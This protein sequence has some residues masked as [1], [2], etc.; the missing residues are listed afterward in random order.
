MAITGK[1]I[2]ELDEA[3][4]NAFK[5]IL[6]IGEKIIDVTY[7]DLVSAISAQELIPGQFY[8]ITDFQTVHWM[9]TL[10]ES[11]EI[12]DLIYI[13]DG[14]GAKVVNT[15]D[16]VE[17]LVVLATSENT[18][19]KEAYS[20]LYP[21]DIIYYE[22][23]ITKCVSPFM[24]EFYDV[25]LSEAVPGF[26]GAILKRN[27]TIRNIELNMDWRNVKYRMW[28]ITQPA[29]NYETEYSLN[30]LV[31]GIDS[32]IYICIKE[33][34]HVEP[35]VSE[36]W[37][38]YWMELVDLTNNHSGYI[39]HSPLGLY[40]S[41]L[42][43]MS[44]GATPY[45]PVQDVED[46]VDKKTIS[47][48]DT[49]SFGI[50]SKGGMMFE[51]VCF[52]FA[53]FVIVGQFLF[54]T[55][56]MQCNAISSFNISYLLTFGSGCNGL[57]FEVGNSSMIFGSGC[58]SM[59]FGSDCRVMTFGSGC[60]NMTFGSGCRVMTFGSDCR[61]MTFG[62]Y[63]NSMTF[64]S[65]C[66]SMSFE[67]GCYQMTFPNN[68][69]RNGFKQGVGGIDYTNGGIVQI[70]T[71]ITVTHQ[72]ANNGSAEVVQYYLDY[73]IDHY[74]MVYTTGVIGVYVL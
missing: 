13:E 9:T 47:D 34:F 42:N 25:T 44:E 37:G 53:C 65:N 69:A 64:G 40:N 50:V 3:S 20:A 49:M 23:D 48:L 4:V 70:T 11:H 61:I 17:P 1:K 5:D 60:G 52:D 36:G 74:E 62:S 43:R 67:S 31:T 18:I 22:W 39:A 71:G 28:N 45:I 15:A 21:Q 56:G 55:F 54:T 7:A 59:T 14:E 24:K 26:K 33:N 72:L 51:H 57:I 16:A 73:V 19:S 32:K 12:Q 35:S 27:D 66:H 10:G 29:Y 8:R 41:I 2:S 6:G 38:E 46:F 68:T 58:F 30:S 63:C